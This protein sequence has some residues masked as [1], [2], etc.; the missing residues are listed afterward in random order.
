MNRVVGIILLLVSLI[1]SVESTSASEESSL[2]RKRAASRESSEISLL[3]ESFNGRCPF[4]AITAT[5]I[6]DNGEPLFLDEAITVFACIRL[7]S[8]CDKS[9]VREALVS[10]LEQIKLQYI[11]Q[12]SNLY[13]ILIKDGKT[14]SKLREAMVPFTAMHMDFMVARIQDIVLQGKV[15]PKLGSE[16]IKGAIESIFEQ[17]QKELLQQFDAITCSC[18]NTEKSWKLCIFNEMFFSK[19]IPVSQ[20]YI[21][22]IINNRALLDEDDHTIFHI[23]FLSWGKR[24]FSS[25]E[26]SRINAQL[27]S[28]QTSHPPSIKRFFSKTIDL[29]KYISQISSLPEGSN[30]DY[31]MNMSQVI[32]GKQPICYYKKSSYCSENDT[33]LQ[34]GYIY[35]V[36]DGQDHKY[37]ELPPEYDRIADVIINNISTEVCYDLCSGVRFNNNWKNE[38]ARSESKLHILVSNWVSLYNNFF[39]LPPHGKLIIHVDPILLNENVFSLRK[40]IVPQRDYNIDPVFAL[41]GSFSTPMAPLL[42]GWQSVYDE[43]LKA[44]F[45]ISKLIKNNHIS[46]IRLNLQGRKYIIQSYDLMD[47]MAKM[48]NGY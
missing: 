42:R 17:R 45:D 28:E 34:S 10:K 20:E 9:H 27:S 32:L 26:I 47:A 48:R 21:T 4:Y 31:L 14:I 1:N 46:A 33:L 2:K 43:K 13:D 35:D 22:N 36:G 24:P 30:R 11:E 8:G 15:N 6:S 5:R 25:G 18:E 37:S 3:N 19:I 7:I 44:S 29:S 38:K 16:R 23:N 40:E 41:T 39:F 12:F